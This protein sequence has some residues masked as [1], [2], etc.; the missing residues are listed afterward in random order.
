M[1]HDR[2]RDQ[3]H[4]SRATVGRRLDC[5]GARIEHNRGRF[6]VVQNCRA[7]IQKTFIHERRH[8][9]RLAR[10]CAGRGGSSRFRCKDEIVR[11]ADATIC[12]KFLRASTHTR[13]SAA[14]HIESRAAPEMRVKFAF[15]H[16][17]HGTCQQEKGGE[18]AFAPQRTHRRRCS[19]EK[20]SYLLI[21]NECENVCVCV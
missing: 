9:N 1:A 16:A 5:V 2:R 7:E 3:T 11:R 12:H 20:S 18:A 15:L 19:T 21:K 14:N 17:T 6:A 4:I 8:H 10:S 13:R